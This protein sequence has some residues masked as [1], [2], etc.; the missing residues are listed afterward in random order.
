MFNKKRKLK[1]EMRAR[2]QEAKTAIFRIPMCFLKSTSLPDPYKIKQFKG[3]LYFFFIYVDIL[4][5]LY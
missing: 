2:T 3:P 1:E 5:I 4:K